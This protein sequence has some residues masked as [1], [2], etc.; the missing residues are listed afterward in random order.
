MNIT[1]DGRRVAD[2]GNDPAQLA[3]RA[4]IDQTEETA[5]PI[6]EAAATRN[7]TDAR[8]WQWTSLL[9]RSLDRREEAIAAM[10]RA[11]QLCPTDPSIAHGLAHVSLEAGVDAVPLFDR[12][13]RLAP[14]NGAILLGMAAAELAQGAGG[15]AVARLETVLNAQP[16]WIE[17]HEQIAKLRWMLG[18]RDGFADSYEKALARAPQNEMLWISYI[19]TLLHARDYRGAAAALARA[20]RAGVR[21]R[22]IDLN[23]AII[24]SETGAM[25][26]ADRLFSNVL[27]APDD[28]TAVHYVRH[29]LRS[30]RIEQAG[31][32]MAP[33]IASAAS[34]ARWPYA[35]A[36]WR[37]MGDERLS[38]LEPY[39]SLISVVD[40]TNQ[41]PPLE[42]LADRLRQLHQAQS[43]QLDQSVRSGTQTDGILFANID[44]LIQQVRRA[45]VSAV[46]AYIARLP[47]RDPKHPTLAP[48]RDRRPRFA[49]SWS[50]RLHGAG[51]H[52][53]H[54]HPAGWISSALYIALPD[55]DAEGPE[56]GWLTLGQPE[57]ELGL[58]INPVRTIRPRPGQLVLCP[59]TMW[60]GTIPFAHGERLTIA[61]DVAQP[62]V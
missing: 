19:I 38:W 55:T 30:G 58:S 36:I 45:V 31:A 28:V 20:R 52:A 33:W 41:L 60:H 49:G 22:A 56:A 5:L 4:L 44:P 13:M 53:N 46:E 59:S 48:R 23:D 8:L 7:A 15:H 61:F 32:A 57:I 39:D 37:L 50:V 2:V 35:A 27:A 62:A 21:G 3:R 25:A 11:A 10:D 29:L 54:V 17:G 42:L 9:L 34:G 1:T 6:V 43:Q 51:Y 18:V 40:L 12:A 24:R 47:A 26:E 16:L 14:N